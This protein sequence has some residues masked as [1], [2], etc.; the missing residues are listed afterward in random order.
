VR[1]K[2]MQRQRLPA[3]RATTTFNFE[4]G[5]QRYVASAS[6]FDDGRLAELFVN[7][8]RAGSGADIAVTDAAVA[9]SIALQY[10]A[11]VETI[12]AALKRNPDGS[13]Q[14]PLGRVLDLLTLEA[15]V[16]PP[17]KQAGR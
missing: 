6:R 15:A 11:D 14:G 10:G 16:P 12:R 7:C 5:G 13:A 2:I 17:H 1:N 3:R 9:I 8:V 4:F